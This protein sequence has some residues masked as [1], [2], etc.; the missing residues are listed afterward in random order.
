MESLCAKRINFCGTLPFGKHWKDRQIALNI[1]EQNIINKVKELRD[2]GLSFEKIASIMNTMG[3][4]TKT[5]KTKW[6]AKTTRDIIV[7]NS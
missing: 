5:G 3:I 4:K 2:Q 6:Y 7:R 1:R